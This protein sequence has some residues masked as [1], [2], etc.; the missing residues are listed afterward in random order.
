VGT[1]SSRGYPAAMAVKLQGSAVVG[2]LALP[3][4]APPDEST[5]AREEFAMD[6]RLRK[7][8]SASGVEPLDRCSTSRGPSNNKNWKLPS[9]WP[10]FP[11]DLNAAEVPASAIPRMASVNLRRW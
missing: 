4:A 10:Q 9:R 11:S 1:A 2:S 5:H 6:T 8:V 3:R 7:V